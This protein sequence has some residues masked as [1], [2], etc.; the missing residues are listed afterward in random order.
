MIYVCSSTTSLKPYSAGQ[1]DCF[2]ATCL[3]TP[4]FFLTSH[5]IKV[6]WEVP[7]A[8]SLSRILSLHLCSTSSLSIYTYCPAALSIYLLSAVYTFSA[9]EM[10]Q[11]V[12]DLTQVAEGLSFK[13]PFES[14][15][16]DL[17]QI[18]QSL[19]NFVSSSVEKKEI[20]LVSKKLIHYE[21]KSDNV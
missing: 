15:M 8:S 20:T 11:A 5:H 16:F 3:P 9:L 6:K 19:C 21:H 12:R 14:L 13:I 1:E 17:G 10:L 2:W 7:A 18:T 4:S